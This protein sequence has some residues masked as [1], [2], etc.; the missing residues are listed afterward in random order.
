MNHIFTTQRV[1]TSEEIDQLNHVNNVVYLQWVQD[2]AEQH[3]AELSKNNPQPDYIWVVIRHEIDYLQQAVLGDTITLKTWVGETQ[4]VKS[5][6]HVEIYKDAVLLVKAQTTWC[7]LHAKTL[8]P[9]RITES[10]INTLL[11]QK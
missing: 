5:V 6:R 2:I 9:T 8:R 1:V 10:V 11:P 7:L 4:G 3:W